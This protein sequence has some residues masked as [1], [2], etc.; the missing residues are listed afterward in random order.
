MATVKK[1]WQYLK[2]V[3]RH[4]WFVFWA[5][6]G[7]RVPI[8]VAFF[9]DWDKFLPE[10]WFPYVNRFYGKDNNVDEAMQDISYQYA[11]LHHQ[12]RNRHHWQYWRLGRDSGEQVL[13][14]MP[15]LYIRE[16][17]ADWKGAGRA[18]GKPDYQL[19]YTQNYEIIQLHPETRNRV[20]ELLGVQF[21]SDEL[22]QAACT[23]DIESWTIQTYQE[24]ALHIRRS[25]KRR[26]TMSLGVNVPDWEL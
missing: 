14:P 25:R 2:Y 26:L 1:H 4:K 19:W 7:L 9:H 5:C 12:Q 23:A 10:E 8:W 13:L 20:D 22:E 11:W 15:E 3:L 16:M 18:L 6:I 21:S 17:V 24:A